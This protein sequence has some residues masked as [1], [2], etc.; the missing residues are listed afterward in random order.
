MMAPPDQLDAL[1]R[2]KA[3]LAPLIEAFGEVEVLIRPKVESPE[4]LAERMS[5]IRKRLR[6]GVRA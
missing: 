6:K 1:R 4:F 2:H 3:E 5:R